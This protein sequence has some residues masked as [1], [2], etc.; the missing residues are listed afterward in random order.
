[1]IHIAE[2]RKQ[3]MLILLLILTLKHLIEKYGALEKAFKDLENGRVEANVEKMNSLLD[4]VQQLELANEV[5][6]KQLTDAG[7]EPDPMPAA[8]FHTHHLIV[9]T[10]DRT[11]LEEDELIKEKSIVTNDKINHLN[12]ELNVSVSTLI[13]GIENQLHL[14]SA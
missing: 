9:G 11:F 1:M 14:Y 7:I 4:S 8:Q 6:R 5:F 2:Y 3:I 13:A 10:M 12:S